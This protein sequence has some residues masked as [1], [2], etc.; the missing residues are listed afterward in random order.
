MAPKSMPTVCIGLEDAKT[1]L[2]L[3]EAGEV[4]VEVGETDYKKQDDISDA[5]FN[6]RYVVKEADDEV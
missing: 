3:A 6:L 5:I 4:V 2:W 1:L